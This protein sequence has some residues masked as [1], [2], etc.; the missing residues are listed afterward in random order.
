MKYISID[1]L[2]KF[3]EIYFYRECKKFNK[4]Y[5]SLKKLKKFNE[6]YFSIKTKKI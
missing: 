1:K 2:K 6:K 5:I 3:N 4:K